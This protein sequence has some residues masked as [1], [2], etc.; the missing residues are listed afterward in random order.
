MASARGPIRTGDPGPAS[1]RWA[2]SIFGAVGPFRGGLRAAA[3]TGLG[4]NWYSVITGA[5]TGGRSTTWRRST[6]LG[7]D[8]ANEDLAARRRLSARS[9]WSC[10][11]CRTTIGTPP[12]RRAACRVCG[13]TADGTTGS[14]RPSSSTGASEDGGREEFDESAPSRRSKLRDPGRQTL[15][16]QFRPGRRS[17]APATRPDSTSSWYVDSGINTLSRNHSRQRPETRRHTQVNSYG[18][19]CRSHVGLV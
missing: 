13:P 8:P 7:G 18:G 17:P 10:R 5:G 11:G 2:L 9:A 6:V 14:S 12:G 16:G 4:H 3:P 19:W 15:L 1:H